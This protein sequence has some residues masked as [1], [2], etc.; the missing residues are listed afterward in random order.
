MRKN[1]I[2]K[3][4]R[5]LIAQYPSVAKIQESIAGT[6]RMGSFETV[7]HYVSAVA[8]FV[9]FLG[10]PDPEVALKKLQSG[11][12]N[13]GEKVDA[14]IDYAL[15]GLGRSHATVRSYIMGIKK[16]LEL[17]SV[18][19]DWAKIELP[20]ATET[21]E[22]D[23]APTKE[24]LKTI[25]IHATSAR[26]RFAVFA[27][28]SSGLRIGTLL[29]LKIGDVDSSS[30]PDVAVVKVEAQRGRKFGAKRRGSGRFYYTFLTLEAKNALKEYVQKRE[31]AGEQVT[32]ESPLVGD[33][34]NKGEHITIEAFEKVWKRI[35][36][37]AGLDQK[38]HRYYMLHVHTLRKYF[39]SNCIGVDVSYRERWMG[40]KGLYLDESY[41]RAEESLHIAEY[42]KAASHL[43]IYQLPTEEK[44]LRSQMLID[45]A[46][47]QGYEEGQ[48]KRLEDVLARSKDVEEGIAEFRKLKED[49][50]ESEK[51]P[52]AKGPKHIIAK[53]EDELLHHLD[54]GCRLIQT[55]DTDRFLLEKL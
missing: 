17:N 48:I 2:R 49:I 36:K 18:K 13:A 19:V 12:I 10:I 55:L 52:T 45:F 31:S 1:V 15:D 28:S 35:L 42:R 3:F 5:E 33:W 46:K 39:R 9:N 14:F 37:K 44:K 24:E 27:L 21:V 54:D 34:A 8:K 7:E 29:S 38:T 50:N 22:T 23:R 11:E 30:Y 6:R 32:S 51:T 16:W 41:F 25:L 26:D 47:L 40:H 43:A 20:T 53:G 4:A